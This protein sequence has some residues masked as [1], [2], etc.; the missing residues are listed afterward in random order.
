MLKLIASIE[1][2]VEPYNQ[3]KR[4]FGWTATADSILQKVARLCKVISRTEH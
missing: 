3:H 1:R 2:Y 4:L